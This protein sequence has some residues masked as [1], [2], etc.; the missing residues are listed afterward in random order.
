MQSTESMARQLEGLAGL[1]MN[2]PPTPIAPSG[3]AVGSLI[4]G[5]RHLDLQE[6]FAAWWDYHLP[7]APDNLSTIYRKPVRRAA[8]S[9]KGGRC[10]LQPRLA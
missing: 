8:A 1:L 9:C 7:C 5:P 6:P 4:D 10:E 3:W 2:F